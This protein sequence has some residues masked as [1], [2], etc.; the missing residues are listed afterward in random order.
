M[1]RVCMLQHKRRDRRKK[2]S[3]FG[4][5]FR[6]QT[7]SR[8]RCQHPDAALHREKTCMRASEVYI[9]YDTAPEASVDAYGAMASYGQIFDDCSPALP[10]RS[11]LP[12]AGQADPLEPP[13]V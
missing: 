5:Q 12:A 6:S 9:R 10:L 2:S 13:P 8:S 11:D 1:K 3:I 7:S 4:L